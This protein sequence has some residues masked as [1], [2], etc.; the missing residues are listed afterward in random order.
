MWMGAVKKDVLF[1][2]YVISIAVTSKGGIVIQVTV[3]ICRVWARSLKRATLRKVKKNVSWKDVW[4]TCD[5]GPLCRGGT[6]LMV[7]GA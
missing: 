3:S 1:I 7:S 2:L 4:R 5:Q 6:P